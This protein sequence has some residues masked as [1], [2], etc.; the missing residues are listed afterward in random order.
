MSDGMNDNPWCS[1]LTP[2]ITK[3][4]RKVTPLSK[5]EELA[6]ALHEAAEQCDFPLFGDHRDLVWWAFTNCSNYGGIRTYNTRTCVITLD[7]DLAQHY[8]D[9]IEDGGMEEGE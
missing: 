7:G 5:A 6:E 8:M 3:P 2:V 4:K 1:V 9:V